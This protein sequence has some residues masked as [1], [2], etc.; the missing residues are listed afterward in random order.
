[1]NIHG[2][3][4]GTRQ[5]LSKQVVAGERI[6]YLTRNV[7]EWDNFQKATYRT[8]R[9]MLSYDRKGLNSYISASIPIYYNKENYDSCTLA[10][11]GINIQKRTFRN[12]AFSYFKKISVYFFNFM[13]PRTTP[14]FLLIQME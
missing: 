14:S 6:N 1:Y 3:Y 8:Y 7:F 11:L 13:M 12:M 5:G 2:I 9:L 10:L 4:I